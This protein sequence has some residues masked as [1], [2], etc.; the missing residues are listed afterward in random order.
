VAAGGELGGA[1]SAYQH[2]QLHRLDKA[3]SGGD[4]RRRLMI[5]SVYDLPFRKGGRWEIR[6]RV[7]NGI[8]GGWGLSVIAEFRDGLPYG[9]TMLTNTSN[10]FGTSQRPNLL[11][12]PKLS[13]SSRAAL[14][15]RYFDTTALAAPP[16][17][18]FGNA[19]R[20]IGF[21]PGVIGFDGSV[22]K[23]WYL[24]ESLRLQFRTDFYNFPNRPQFSN[25]NSSMGQADFG[26]VTSILS[27]ST[28]RLLQMSTRL[29]F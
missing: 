22:N 18:Y 13:H 16:A 17:G 7:L 26:R 28:G 6:N 1:P 12:D 9:V 11:R 4:V 19:G 14:T 21:G 20:T 2:P 27:G 24:R 5:S 29:E 15:A 3:N 25:P 10:T 23:Q 8:L